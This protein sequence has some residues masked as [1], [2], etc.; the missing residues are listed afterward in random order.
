M[1][2]KVTIPVKRFSYN[3]L[4]VFTQQ[5]FCCLYNVAWST[6][7]L[8]KYT[9]TVLVFILY[10]P[11]VLFFL[12]VNIHCHLMF[13]LRITSYEFPVFRGRKIA[14]AGSARLL[15]ALLTGQYCVSLHF[16]AI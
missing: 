2:R 14:F 9:Y 16:M 7:V 11:L 3:C 5:L 15:H 1:G 12:L 13:W 6:T 10:L 8:Y 4:R